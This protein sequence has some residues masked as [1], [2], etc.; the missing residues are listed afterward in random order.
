[1]VIVLSM[2]Q[3]LSAQIANKMSFQAVIRNASGELVINGSVGL[4]MSILQ[5]SVSGMVVYSETHSEMAN[6]HGLLTLEIG[7][8]T[9]V[10]GVYGDIDWSNGP[11]F[12][13]R[14]LD[15]LGGT[16]YV[17]SGTSQLLSVPYAMYANVSDTVLNAADTSSINE[18]QE[19]RVATT[20]DTLYLSSSNYVIISGISDANYPPI[21]FDGYQY[22]TVHIG[23]QIWFAE[24]LRTTHYNDGT[25][26]PNVT[27]NT[28]WSG[29]SSG[30]RAYYANDSTQYDSVY[31][32]LYN[33]YAVETGN[34]CPTGW[35]VPTDEDWTTLTD[36]L[37]GEVIAG[38][39]LKE[40]DT[41]HWN[42]PNIDATDEVGFTGLPG[43]LRSDSGSFFGIRGGGYWWSA[44]PVNSDNS[45]YRTLIY[46]NAYVN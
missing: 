12:L 26:I 8:G 30:A 14:E 46:S 34:L 32:A 44:T 20:G 11:Y 4:K 27:D 2:V 43:G 25:L 22:D 33:W 42:S 24:N 35:H 7:G 28:A 18:I 16:N 41:V 17:V 23:T 40:K 31:G 9:V 29:L 37:G 6:E 36:T 45:W 13:K 15:P 5:G 19:L 1:M 3:G 10:S 39:K 38:G 21:D